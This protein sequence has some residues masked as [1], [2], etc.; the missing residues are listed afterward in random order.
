M[1]EKAQT[2]ESTYQSGLTSICEKSETAPVLNKCKKVTRI[3]INRPRMA[4]VA[5]YSK[6][7]TWSAFYTI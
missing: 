1:Q 6:Q 7:Y 4:T 5:R 3:A 2:L